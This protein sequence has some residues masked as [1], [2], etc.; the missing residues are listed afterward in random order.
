MTVATVTRDASATEYEPRELY[1]IVVSTG[2]TYRHTSA[3]RDISHGGELYTAIAIDRGELGVATP[4][5]GRELEVLIPIDHPLARRYTMHGTPPRLITITVTVLDGATATQLFTGDVTSMA[6]E[7]NIAK[8]R[9]PS[10][11]SEA[12]L[13]VLPNVSCSKLCPYLLYDEGSCKVSRTGSSPDGV[14]FQ[15]VTTTLHVDG[16]SVRVDLSNVPA[17]H[18]L[19]ED[20]L[21]GGEIVHSSGER[22]TIA[23]QADLNPGI[24]TVTV[25]T[26]G[27]LIPGMKLGDTVTL[28]AGCRHDVATCNDKFSNVARH[29]GYPY[30]P[31]ANFYLNGEIT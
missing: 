25:I 11:M 5:N 30:L 9:V 31:T 8:L 3:T 24:S 4:G 15:L 27:A 28:Q 18:A 17:D 22:S 19:R 12:I 7:G 1:E 29:G 2:D 14:P 10:R 20:W 21:V 16:R 26:L 23:A 13:R 6:W